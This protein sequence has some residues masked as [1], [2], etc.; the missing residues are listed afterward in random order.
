MLVKPACDHVTA[1]MT[2]RPQ[3]G[4]LAQT[5]QHILPWLCISKHLCQCHLAQTQIKV[6][7]PACLKNK[8]QEEM[9]TAPLI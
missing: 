1:Q 4:S 6:Q 3:C 7:L 5:E 2:P 8:C 9:T